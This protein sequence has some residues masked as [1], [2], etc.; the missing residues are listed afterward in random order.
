MSA[1]PRATK[2]LVVEYVNYF[3]LHFLRS[4]CNDVM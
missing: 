1:Q 2:K 4:W 3:C